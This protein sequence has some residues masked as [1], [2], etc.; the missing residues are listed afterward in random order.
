MKSI[1]ERNDWNE[2][3]NGIS[4][5]RNDQKGISYLRKLFNSKIWA[6]LVAW[7]LGTWVS[8]THATNISD[9]PTYIEQILRNA[10]LPNPNV[11]RISSEI[12]CD[13]DITDF[14]RKKLRNDWQA[15]NAWFYW[16]KCENLPKGN[17]SFF[18]LRLTDYN[19]WKSDA[20]YVYEKYYIDNE[21]KIVITLPI[22]TWTWIGYKDM[23]QKNA[24]L[25]Q[26][27]AT[28][29]NNFKAVNDLLRDNF[30]AK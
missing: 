4:N 22:E 13:A 10:D 7:I 11:Q 27:N 30:S 23:K 25:K 24:E 29:S 3:I 18:V 12:S 2:N 16:N 26:Q 17:I 9:N 19:A 1:N 14:I 6:L 21:N 28:F 20:T 15:N 8:P 5:E